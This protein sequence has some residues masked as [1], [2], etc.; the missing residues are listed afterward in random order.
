[1]GRPKF[2]AYSVEFA[3]K[4]DLGPPSWENRQKQGNETKL[5]LVLIVPGL[6]SLAW[7]P[8]CRQSIGQKKRNG[9]NS[10][11]TIRGK[12]LSCYLQSTDDIVHPYRVVSEEHLPVE[13]SFQSLVSFLALP[14]LSHS[15]LAQFSVPCLFCLVEPGRAF[16]FSRLHSP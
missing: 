8:T 6:A 13:N 1:M 9:M 4:N 5:P 3:R 12:A 14:T 2:T 11:L 10:G 16:L 7:Q 15:T